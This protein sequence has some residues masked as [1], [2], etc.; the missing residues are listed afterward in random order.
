MF[1]RYFGT[2]LSIWNKLE[3]IYYYYDISNHSY[4]NSHKKATGR[5]MTSAILE[6][7]LLLKNDDMIFGAH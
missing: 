4:I 7:K 2:D 3:K 1:L 5:I 6:I